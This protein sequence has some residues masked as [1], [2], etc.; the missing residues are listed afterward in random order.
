MCINKNLEVP[1]WEKE[2]LTLVEAS[3][4]FGIGINKLRTL[5]KEPQCPFVL[6]VGKKKKLI[7]RKRF[8]EYLSMKKEV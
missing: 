7:K 8:E 1:I 6:H 5:A 2:C 3:E 4:Y